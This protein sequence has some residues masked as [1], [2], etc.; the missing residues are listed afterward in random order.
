MEQSTRMINQLIELLYERVYDINSFT[1][2]MVC[3]TLAHLVEIHAIPLERYNALMEL[4]YDRLN[5]KT[6]VVRKSTLQLLTQLIDFNPFSP[7]LNMGYY[8]ERRKELDD[9]LMNHKNQLFEWFKLNGPLEEREVLIEKS[10]D[11][12]F[13]YFLTRP[14]YMDNEDIKQLLNQIDM[15]DQGIQF[16]TL[17]HKTVLKIVT[18]LKS[19]TNTDVLESLDFLTRAI[20]FSVTDSAKT[21]QKSAIQLFFHF[22]D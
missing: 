19:K 22:I 1:R 2:S 13:D 9:G 3:K 12:Q 20:N 11:E 16:I 6:A 18:L 15:V 5:D 10:I 17:C 7:H 21:F 4:A 14:V 8:D